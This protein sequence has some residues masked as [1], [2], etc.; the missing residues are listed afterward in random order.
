MQLVF[1]DKI[2]FK[3]IEKQIRKVSTAYLQ[4]PILQE[5]PLFLAKWL[6]LWINTS[7]LSQLGYANYWVNHSEEYVHNIFSDIHTKNIA[8]KTCISY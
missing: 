6:H 4:H 5:V 8:L 2:I 1:Q 3:N 7:N